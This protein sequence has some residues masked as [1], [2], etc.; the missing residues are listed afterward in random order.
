[1]LNLYAG[2]GCNRARWPDHFEVTAVEIDPDIAKIYRHRFEDDVV[3]VADAHEYL[4]KNFRDYD[5]IWASPPCP[6]HSRIW[7]SQKNSREL[8]Y[9]DM[10]LYQEIVLLESWHEGEWVVEN[11]KPY[12]EPLIRPTFTIDRHVFWSSS[13]IPPFR[14][15]RKVHIRDATK[16]ELAEYHRI[17]GTTFEMMVELFGGR[18]RKL[19]RNGL[20]EDMG[21]Y[22][23]NSMERR[24]SLDVRDGF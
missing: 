16:E 19:L 8:V 7:Y 3:I 23:A 1:M 11:V 13:M 4:R 24:I 9:P 21:R 14:Y 5:F 22:I 17:D 10:R 15:R 20:H 2:I 12:Y 6:S 18:S